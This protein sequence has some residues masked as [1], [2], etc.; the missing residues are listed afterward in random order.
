MLLGQRHRLPACLILAALSAGLSAQTLDV[1][2]SPVSQDPQFL[3]SGAIFD[4]ALVAFRMS[5]SGG[6]VTLDGL[7]VTLSGSGSFALDV[8]ELA[9]WLDDGD[10]TFNSASDQLIW[11]DTPSV[12]K[13]VM[14]FGP[15]PV[16]ASGTSEDIWIVA[17]FASTAGSSL[18]KSYR[19][20]ITS[21]ND[22]SVDAASTA[23]LGTPLPQSTPVKLI[24]FSVTNAVNHVTSISITGSGFTPPVEVYAGGVLVQGAL[25]VNSEHTEVIL[26]HVAPDPIPPLPL[27][28]IRSSSLGLKNTNYWYSFNASIGTTGFGDLPAGCAAEAN[29][30]LAFLALLSVIAA[31]GVARTLHR[32]AG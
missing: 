3:E 7:S 16:V 24:F 8:S 27:V 20:S 5:A 30:S 19:V 14:T 26:Y 4:H 31:I 18:G 29:S 21:A 6:N 12:P 23:T 22:V 32:G 11:I 1:T 28:S 15:A 13:T 9:A 25:T 2:K 17:K 10:G